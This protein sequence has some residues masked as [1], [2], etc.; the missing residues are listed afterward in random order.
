[1]ESRRKEVHKK[2][3]IYGKAEY[4]SLQRLTGRRKVSSDRLLGF[5]KARV[6]GEK[7]AGSMYVC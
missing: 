2:E 4:K 5:I 6:S 7:L 1:M 3:K